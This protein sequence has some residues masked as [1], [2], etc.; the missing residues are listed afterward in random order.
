MSLV[1]RFAQGVMAPS[2]AHDAFPSVVRMG[3]GERMSQ[4]DLCPLI[5]LSCAQTSLSSSDALELS[6]N[7]QIPSTA[8]GNGIHALH[9]SLPIGE[10]PHEAKVVARMAVAR[11]RL[12]CTVRSH[13][14]VEFIFFTP[15][16]LARLV[17]PFSSFFF[18]LLE[19]YGL[20]LHHLL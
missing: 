2:T 9:L 14:G 16:T 17:L 10:R 13:S 6:A 20:Q 5:L 12:E 7:F 3:K 4:V 8:H 1:M 11:V 19:W 18:M 15:Y